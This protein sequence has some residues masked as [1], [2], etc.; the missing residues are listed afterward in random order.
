MED[1]DIL[2][3]S[4]RGF[5][6]LIIGSMISLSVLIYIVSSYDDLRK[7]KQTT[8]NLYN[9]LYELKYHTERLLT[10]HKLMDQKLLWQEKKNNFENNL[11]IFVQVRG[12]Q[13]DDFHMLWN[14]IRNEIDDILIQLQKPVFQEENTIDKS[15]LRRLGELLNRDS[16]SQYYIHLNQLYS[17]IEYL[18]QYQTFFMDELTQMRELHKVEILHSIENIKTVAIFLPGSILIFTILLAMYV[19][20]K[21]KKMELHLVKTSNSL[22]KSLVELREKS[23]TLN[24]L[25]YHDP[26]TGLAS[27]TML[28]DRLDQA[29]KRAK[30]YDEKVAVLFIDLDRFKEVND[31]FGHNIGDELLQIISTRFTKII[32]EQDT[33]ARI[34][35][36]EFV[37][38]LENVKDVKNVYKLCEKIIATLK[39]PI[40][41]S[42]NTLH[43]GSSIGISIYPTDA[44]SADMLLRNSDSAMYFA[45]DS[46]RSQFKL[47][48]EDMTNSAIE[49]VKIEHQL[50]IAL[51]KEEFEVYYQPQVDARSDKLISL[52]ALIRWKHPKK[53]LLSPGY[54]LPLAE[55]TGLIVPISEW[56]LKQVCKQQ[57]IWQEKGLALVRVAVNLSGQQLE[58]TNLYQKVKDMLEETNCNPN[59]LELEITEGFMMKNPQESIVLMEKLSKFGIEMSIDD[60]GTG[61]SSM[62]YI[63]KLPIKKLKI[64]KTFI[65]DVMTNLKDVAIIRT[66][67][68]LANGLRLDVIAEGVENM[69]QRD[70]LLKEGCNNIQ[71]YLYSKPLP[72]EEVEKVL[73]LGYIHV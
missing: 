51:D 31:S 34:G 20:R 42:N 14:V 65:D 24:Y 45:K 56:V 22:K 15:L 59:L 4:L 6:L 30:R 71:G 69:D 55:S 18:K 61:Y 27:R 32:R 39:M 72:V 57:V 16:K 60:F 37:V 47:Y 52:E 63:K 1:N 36:D 38:V 73:K 5:I 70:F 49:K 44:N 62:A 33:I 7:R 28:M 41:L 2:K 29:I 9:S 26:L 64:D 40:E 25:A 68:A 11:H 13:S 12:Q 48:T 43:V 67:I 17:S 10:T 35:G 46:G 50:R 23:D 19:T 58:D 8:E 66:I 3:I 53:G 54:F 21:V